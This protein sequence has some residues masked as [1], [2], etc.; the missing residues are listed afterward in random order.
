MV[1]K[2]KN[3]FL[4]N[5][6]LLFSVLILCVIGLTMI[7]SSSSVLSESKFSYLTRQ[8][9]FMAVGV[10]VMLVTYKININLF[11]KIEVYI[12]ICV[13]FALKFGSI[14]SLE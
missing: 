8:A 12:Y 10:L 1:K 4:Y 3:Y 9:V 13:Y 14:F 6:I 7:F 11:F 2:Y 5:N